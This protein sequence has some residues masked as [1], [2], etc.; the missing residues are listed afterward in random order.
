MELGHL[1][2]FRH[3]IFRQT[4]YFHGSQV[5]EEVNLGIED[6]LN[7]RASSDAAMKRKVSPLPK[8]K[9]QLPVHPALGL[10]TVLT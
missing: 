1:C 4:G 5:D 3:F 8:S 2:C 6:W 7:P 10:V 9:S